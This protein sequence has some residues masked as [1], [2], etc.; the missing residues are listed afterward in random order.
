M[1][2]QRVE[3]KSEPRV[4]EK[5]QHGQ[6]AQRLAQHIAHGDAVR[7]VQRQRKGLKDDQIIENAV[8]G[9]HAQRDADA[10][11][12][13]AAAFEHGGEGGQQRRKDRIADNQFKIVRRFFEEVAAQLHQ[14]QQRPPEKGQC[15]AKQQTE[16]ADKAQRIEHCVRGRA[17]VI[18]AECLTDDDACARADDRKERQ[19]QA[20]ELVG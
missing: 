19:R 10:E 6:A 14:P 15:D 12:R 3:V 1:R 18:C 17:A 13:S 20:D 5:Q 2:V 8:E 7:A 16:H 4:Q 9:V 11:L